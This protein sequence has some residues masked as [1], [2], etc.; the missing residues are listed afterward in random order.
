MNKVIKYSVMIAMSSGAVAM[1]AFSQQEKLRTPESFARTYY[2]SMREY[3]NGVAAL[4]EVEAVSGWDDAPSQF[5]IV[6][7][8]SRRLGDGAPDRGRH[9]LVI[10]SQSSGVIG[11]IA[12]FSSAPS[13]THSDG[14]LRI[15][16]FPPVALATA[17]DAYGLAA[18]A[19][20]SAWVM[21]SDLVAYGELAAERLMAAY[22]R[23]G[24]AG[25]QGRS[26]VDVLGPSLGSER[27]DACGLVGRQSIEIAGGLPGTITKFV[28]EQPM[29]SS[30]TDSNLMMSHAWEVKV[31][32]TL[33][34]SDG[35][36]HPVGILVVGDPCDRDRI[37]QIVVR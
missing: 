16:G 12:G 37:M 15:D 25:C 29:M 32:A 5:A 11:T 30:A 21:Q 20:V 14:M 35:N 17:R 24:R 10:I 27:G 1:I 9:E 33:T 23:E 34:D 31:S 8:S 2:E 13:V 26:V 6:R 4:D 3:R 7:T 19:H 22:F 36:E 18:G 28:I